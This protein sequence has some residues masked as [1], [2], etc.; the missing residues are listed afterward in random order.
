MEI[1][2]LSPDTSIYHLD[3]DLSEWVVRNATA[4]AFA[5]TE[6]FP[7]ISKSKD[8][9]ILS[10]QEPISEEKIAVLK[11][12]INDYKL[13]EIIDQRSGELRLSISEAALKSCYGNSSS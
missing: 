4:W 3:K 7:E 12:Y 2:K 9:W 13:R 8:S 10:F 11:K 6:E 5:R 1:S